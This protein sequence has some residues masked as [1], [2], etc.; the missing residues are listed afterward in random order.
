MTSLSASDRKSRLLVGCGE[1]GFRALP[2]ERHFEIARQFGFKYL[3]FGIGGNQV[4]R[5]PEVPTAEDVAGFRRLVQRFSINTPF[6]CIEND[7]TLASAHLH[8]AMVEKVLGQMQ[9]AAACGATHVRLFAGFTPLSQM[10]E[11][12]W[13]QLIGALQ[14]CQS[15]A[16]KLNLTIAIETHGAI[17]PGPQGEAVHQS[18]V[19]TDRAALTRLLSAMP[20]EIGINYDPGNIKAAEG[21]RERLHLEVLNERINYCHLKDWKRRGQGWDACAIGD[22][23]LDYAKLLPQMQF[24]GVYLIEYEPLGDVEAGIERSLQTLRKVPLTLVF[25]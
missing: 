5:L 4:G 25:A 8:S 15:A 9:A 10:T 20:G 13:Q 11:P 16:E 12:L 1:W 22:D 2:M 24:D 21:S 6:C 19:T 14:T 18:T 3:E 17:S 7:F 23:D